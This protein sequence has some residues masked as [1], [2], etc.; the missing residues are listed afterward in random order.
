MLVRGFQLCLL[1]I[2]RTTF[3][4]KM[5]KNLQNLWFFINLQKITLWWKISNFKKLHVA[6]RQIIRSVGSY[7]PVNW[8]PLGLFQWPEKFT[9]YLIHSQISA[10][11]LI[12]NF[13]IGIVMSEILQYSYLPA[14]YNFEV[15][16]SSSFNY[17]F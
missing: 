2:W 11:T 7:L 6:S 4:T 16:K 9:K 17:H 14:N 3:S 1:W 5:I 13:S 15:V 12:R 10:V 8:T